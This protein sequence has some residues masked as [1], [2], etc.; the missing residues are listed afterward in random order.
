MVRSL[1]DRIPYELSWGEGVERQRGG[2]VQTSIGWGVFALLVALVLVGHDVMLTSPVAHAAPGAMASDHAAGR[3]HVVANM[4]M[5]EEPDLSATP[6]HGAAPCPASRVAKA[7][8]IRSIGFEAE[9]VNP[10]AALSGLDQR[11]NVTPLPDDSSPLLT[12]S[13]RRALLQVFLM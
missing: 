12:A 13:T 1:F 11:L 8:S 7:P 6:P 4:V 5:L 10:L 3:D 2:L 9:R